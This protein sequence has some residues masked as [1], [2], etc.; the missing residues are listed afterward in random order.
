M[1]NLFGQGA[2]AFMM[3]MYALESPGRGF[4]LAFAFGCVLSSVTGSWPGRG[5]WGGRAF[6]AINALQRG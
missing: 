3:L 5:R 2:L 6:W 4:I 1:L